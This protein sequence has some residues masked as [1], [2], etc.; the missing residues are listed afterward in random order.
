MFRLVNLFSES[1]RDFIYVFFHKLNGTTVSLSGKPESIQWIYRKLSTDVF[2]RNMSRCIFA[3]LH[4]AKQRV[5]V[6]LKVVSATFLLVCF[7]RSK[8]EYLS[9]YGKCFLFHFK[10]SFRSRENQILE[11]Y[12]FKFHDVIKC[13]SI[14]QEMYFNE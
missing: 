1:T 4:Y 3:F 5:F 14:K 2:C 9:N 13:L 12:I 6:I 7:F 11:F 8:Q 10:S